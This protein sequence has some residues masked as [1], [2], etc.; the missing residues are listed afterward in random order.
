MSVAII[1]I[2][3]IVYMQFS[4]QSTIYHFHFTDEATEAQRG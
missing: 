3:E 4:Q 2:T 1:I